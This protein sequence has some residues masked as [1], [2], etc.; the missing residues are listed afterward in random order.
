MYPSAEFTTQHRDK[1]AIML[2]PKEITC[3]GEN[4]IWLVCTFVAVLLLAISV[5]M[6]V[7][8]K[9][10][11][12]KAVYVLG[13]LFAATYIMNIPPFYITYDFLPGVVGNLVNTLRIVTSD[14][15]ITLFYEVITEEIS[16][17]A[18]AQAYIVLLGIMHIALPAVS[19]L[20][21]VTVLLRCFSSIQMF[22]ANR[23][24]RPMFVFSEVNERTLCLA[25]S[26][27]QV[28]CDV[29]FAN[30]TADMFNGDTKSKR[31]MICKDESISEL[32]VR[33]KKGKDIYFFCISEDEDLSLSHA[34]Q[35]I[36]RFASVKESEQEKIHIYQFSKHQDFSVFIDSATKGSLDV[37]CVNEYET[38][39]YNLLDQYPLMKYGKSSIH[40]LLHGLS[41]MNM[42]ALK[43][44]AWCGQISGF[45]LRISVVGIDISKRVQELKLTAPGLF[46]DRYDIRFYNCESETQIVDVISRECMDV[47]YIV[48]SDESDNATMEQG[49]L[50]RRLFYKLDEKFAACPPIFCYIKEPAKF[51]LIEN[52]A[53]A[54]AN[55]KRK[56]NYSLTPF[57][58]LDEVFTYE[59]LVDSALE[60]LAKNVHLAYEEIFSDGEIDVK[61][62]LKRYNVFEINKRS[63]R[64]NALHIRYK[65]LSLGLDYTDDPDAQQV[66]LSDYYTD[67]SI[68]Q[69]A[70]S[71]H[72]RWMA[73]L[74][75][76]GW[77]PATKDQVYAYRAS[78]ISK[79]RHNC[80]VLKMHP[81][82][83][84]YA[85]LKELSEDL[86]GKDTTVY[87]EALIQRIPNILGDKWKV[88]GKQYRI[89]KLRE[90]TGGIQN[91]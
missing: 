33:A 51:K 74:E 90:E 77:T 5:R 81:Y 40:V 67:A 29:V 1:Y 19:A 8:K 79:G 53:T 72:D 69:M 21:A 84:P 61:D 48:V 88:A 63:N 9:N 6:Y 56:M 10:S 43:A 54:E 91:V 73:F 23:R 80:P 47:N 44:I 58:S 14:A 34:L 38:L 71:E 7:S 30:S 22:F 11:V 12:F 78:D 89:I 75:T 26:L 52:L 25:K 27:E 36:E 42:V 70:I 20:T 32:D 49:I 16:V 83:C 4:V 17:S 68:E 82:I 18:L 50:L 46:T 86:E 39:I 66:V 41:E 2:F 24:K 60:K 87:D 45:S 15:D 55:P 31:G 59:R 37:H 64:A 13:C 65:L 62:A 57:G 85:Y 28:K 35:L 3:G 76:E